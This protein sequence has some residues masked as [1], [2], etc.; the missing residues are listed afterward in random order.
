M[1]DEHFVIEKNAENG[2]TITTI[3]KLDNEESVIE[4]ARLLGGVSITENVIKNAREMK[5][6]A[7]RTKTSKNI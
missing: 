6:L 2:S 1:A 5:D 4:L 7:D 3:K